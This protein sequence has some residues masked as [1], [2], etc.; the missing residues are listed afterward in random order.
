MAQLTRT[1]M[2]AII[3]GGGSISLGGR[4]VSRIDQLPSAAQ[5]AGNDPAALAATV[6]DLEAQI[7][8]L[9]AQQKQVKAAQAKAEK[10]AAEQAAQQSQ[11]P[12]S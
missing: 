5:L 8:A 10:E 9:Q 7:K 4:I 12:A 11:E 2:E 6:D 1:E 3:R